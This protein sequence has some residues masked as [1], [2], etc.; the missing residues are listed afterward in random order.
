MFDRAL[1]P[2][3]KAALSPES[4]AWMAGLE[5]AGYEPVWAVGEQQPQATVRAY[6]VGKLALFDGERPTRVSIPIVAYVLRAGDLTMSVDAGLSA[7]WRAEIA[8]AAPDDG[9]GPGQRYLPVLDGPTF[10]EQLEAEK[11]DVDRAVCTHLHIDHVGGAGELGVPIEASAEELAEAL[12][13][14]SGGYPA[15]ELA[16]VRFSPIRMDRGP[17]GP[18][19]QHSILAPGLLALA[20]PGHTRGSVSVFACLGGT[21][22]LVCGDAPYPASHQP[23]SDAY[24]GMLRIRRALGE[25]GGTLVLAGHDT[26]ALRAC[27]DGAWLGN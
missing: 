4:E 2:L 3:L 9:P 18:W 5:V 16:G 8:D 10:A 14:E 26:A 24:R 1:P 22:A 17:V 7:R 6:A 21:W 12:S 20:T 25:M 15:E 23:D 19:L 11:I 27:A 13:G